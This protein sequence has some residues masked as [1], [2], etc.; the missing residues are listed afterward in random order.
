MWGGL[1]EVQDRYALFVANVKFNRMPSAMVNDADVEVN[2][3]S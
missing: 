2:D 3:V 1:E